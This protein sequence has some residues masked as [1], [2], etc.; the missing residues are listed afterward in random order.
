MFRGEFYLPDGE[1]PRLGYFSKSNRHAAETVISPFTDVIG[2]SDGLIINFK[3]GG[4]GVGTGVGS[5]VD[6][7]DGSRLTSGVGVSSS[8]GFGDGSV[9]GEIPGVGVIS[10]IGVG[11]TVSVG[12]DSSVGAM[13][14]SGVGET[15]S[16]T[17][18]GS[19]VISSSTA[20][21]A[22]VKA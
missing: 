6:M 7:M 9:D 19:G 17:M 16:P 15:C 4:L 12:V 10:S 18:V 22:G 5:S 2:S 20:R 13:V 21:T 11:V 3:P 8:V 1:F 14:V